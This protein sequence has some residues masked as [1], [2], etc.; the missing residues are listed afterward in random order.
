MKKWMFC[1]TMLLSALLITACS[2]Q[3]AEEKEAS[4]KEVAINEETE[5]TDRIST[6]LKKETL[7]NQYKEFSSSKDEQLLKQATPYDIF[8][9]YWAAVETDDY[10]TMYALYAKGVESGTPSYAEF[11]K[12]YKQYKANTITL[13]GDLKEHGMHSFE[14][15]K[16]D[17]ENWAYISIDEEIG[18]GFGLTKQDG[19]WKVNW[20][21]V[22]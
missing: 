21:P 13:L 19:V 8:L 16:N 5:Q 18:I 9:L 10:E 2:S 11:K 7:I 12:E 4:A 22:G 6:I 1:F 17:Q 15:I 3:V 14:E 20:M